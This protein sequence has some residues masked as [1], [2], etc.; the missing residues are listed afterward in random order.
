MERPPSLA[1]LRPVVRADD[2]DLRRPAWGWAAFGPWRR[3]AASPAPN[4]EAARG[5]Q[6]MNSGVAPATSAAGETL[7]IVITSPRRRSPTR[8]SSRP[9]PTMSS[10]SGATN[11]TV[12]GTTGPALTRCRS[13]T[14]AADGRP[15]RARRRRGDRRRPDPGQ[16]RPIARRG[17]RRSRRRSAR[18]QAAFPTFAIHAVSNTLTNDQIGSVVN[19]DLDGSLRISLPATF[20]ILVLAFGA[21]VAAFVP[22]FLAITALAGGL[23]PARHLQPGSS[24]RSARTRPS[25]SS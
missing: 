8:P 2:R 17:R 19:A 3:P 22:L 21:V 18:A 7:T 24:A 16:H 25:S 12:D 4:T 11:A 10:A 15:A 5:L 9:S 13:R 20:I 1:G 6:A 23:R 14:G